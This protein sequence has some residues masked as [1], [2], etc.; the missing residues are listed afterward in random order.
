M[1]N[2]RL[3]YEE[4]A[5]SKELAEKIDAINSKHTDKQLSD[6]EK[7]AI[8]E[9]EMIPIAKEYGFDFTIDELKQYGNT[10]MELDDSA[11]ENIDGGIIT[12]KKDSN[13]NAVELLV[14]GQ[15]AN[16]SCYLVGYGNKFDDYG[17]G[18]C[19]CVAGGGGKYQ[20]EENGQ[21]KSQYRMLCVVAGKNTS[22][23]EA[24]LV[25]KYKQ[26]NQK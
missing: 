19:A 3:F 24:F 22:N 21:I 12:L 2:I 26:E 9:K 18:S 15:S 14:N 8:L 13:G 11:L 17:I 20:Y 7:F 10:K 4:L 16:A 25:D 1:E 5:Q 23:F 6:D